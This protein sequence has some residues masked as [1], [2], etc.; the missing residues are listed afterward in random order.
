[1]HYD[2]DRVSYEDLLEVFWECHDPTQVNR[3][4]PDVGY[5][6]RSVI[7]YHNEEQRAAAEAAKE[8]MAEHYNKPIA[9]A[10]EP[11]GPFWRAEDYHQ[12]YL[13]K[14]GIGPSCH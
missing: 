1:V 13:E 11:A 7:F 3:Q 6:Y 4:G 14:R 9:T 8:K 12:D 10:I 5:Q 2:P